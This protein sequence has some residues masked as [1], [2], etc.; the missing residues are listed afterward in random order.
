MRYGALPYA[1]SVAVGVRESAI[2]WASMGHGFWLC[3]VYDQTDGEADAVVS[4]EVEQ[5]AYVVAFQPAP[6]ADLYTQPVLF[7]G[8][9]DSL[10]VGDVVRAEHEPGR[11]LEV[12]RQV[13]PHPEGVAG[14][15]GTSR[16]LPR[17][18]GS[19]GHAR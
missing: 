8:L 1:R 6:V 9:P 12:H 17:P 10:D 15:L 11:K 7:E 3:R 5:R 13:S 2:G 4:Q 19:C 14:T 16:S 18:A